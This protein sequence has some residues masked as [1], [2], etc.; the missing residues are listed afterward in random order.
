M[1]KIRRFLLS[2]FKHI[3]DLGYGKCEC[4]GF[5]WNT[6]DQHRIMIIDGRLG[7]FATCEDCWNNKSDEKIIAAYNKLYE[8]WLCGDK[9]NKPFTIEQIGFTRAEMLAALDKE[10]KKRKETQ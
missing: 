9:Y 3:I 2:P 10:L 6:V 5:H 4:C 7:C 8:S 1:N